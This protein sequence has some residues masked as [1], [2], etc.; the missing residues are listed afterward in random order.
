MKGVLYWL[1]IPKRRLWEYH[2]A[3]GTA[4]RSTLARSVSAMAFRQQGDLLL[5]VE[6]G[7]VTA[8]TKGTITGV[9][10]RADLAPDVR[11]NDGAADAMGRY[12]S[13]TLHAGRTPVNHLYRLDP[14][15]T[16]HEMDGGL[17]ASNGIAWSP[18]NRTM[19]LVDS[20]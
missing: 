14:D 5:T 19:Y 15:G 11:F 18:D 2:A 13:G 10:A 12:W 4:H 8:N 7:F 1:D 6:D 16:L 20:G 17:R 3:T 9:I